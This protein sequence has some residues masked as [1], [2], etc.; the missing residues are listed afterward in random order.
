MIGTAV[1]VLLAIALTALQ[2]GAVA[3]LP[4]P[5]SILHLPLIAIIWELSAFRFAQ[6]FT[7]A[8]VS[9]LAIDLLVA[10]S[11]G[12]ETGILLLVTYLLVLLFTRIFTNSSLPALLA[13][14]AAGFLALHAAYLLRNV[15]GYT[16]SGD[17]IG[18]LIGWDRLLPLL[19]GLGLQLA[20]MTVATL[21]AALAKRAIGSAIVL[22]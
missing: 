12:A 17:D 20:V 22:R 6:A 4:S 9:G 16:L 18:L 11:F 2:I 5:Y 14:T 3:A 10:P 8:A 15:V 1:T 7:V 21:L 19:A 13:M